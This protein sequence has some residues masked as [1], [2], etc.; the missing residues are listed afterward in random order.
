MSDDRYSRLH[1]DDGGEDEDGSDVVHCCALS[2]CYIGAETKNS[3]Y[4]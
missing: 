3:K 1:E 4:K 2:L